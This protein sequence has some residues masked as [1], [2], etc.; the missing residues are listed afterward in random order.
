MLPIKA[1]RW[2]R[3]CYLVHIARGGGGV[4]VMASERAEI[5]APKNPL[6]FRRRSGLGRTGPGR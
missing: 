3:L 1:K 5:A 2:A 4:A 6:I